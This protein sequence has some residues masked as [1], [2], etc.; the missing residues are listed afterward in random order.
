[1]SISTSPRINDLFSMTTHISFIFGGQKTS[2]FQ[3][4][5]AV[6]NAITHSCR[7]RC[8]TMLLELDCNFTHTSQVGKEH[9]HISNLEV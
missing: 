1:M 6:R 9:I 3:L 4:L 8:K 2:D 7:L 5:S